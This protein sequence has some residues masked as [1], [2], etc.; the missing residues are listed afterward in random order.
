MRFGGKHDH[1]GLGAAVPGAN[2]AAIEESGDMSSHD[3]LLM[4]TIMRRWAATRLRDASVD[5]ELNTD[6][7]LRHTC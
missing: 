7:G 3:L 5:A 2:P 6:N 1:R 4:H